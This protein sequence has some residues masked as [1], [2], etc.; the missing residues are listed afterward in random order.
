[1]GR[2]FKKEKKGKKPGQDK[3]EAKRMGRDCKRE[4][5]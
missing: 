2:E 1:M 3:Y 5:K 4:K